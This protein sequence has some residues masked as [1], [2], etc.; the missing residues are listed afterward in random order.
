[1]GLRKGDGS[2]IDDFGALGLGKAFL[3]ELRA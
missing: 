3:D 2:F 1:V